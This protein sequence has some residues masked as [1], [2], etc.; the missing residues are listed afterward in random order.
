MRITIEIDGKEMPTA[1]I[2]PSAGLE[3]SAQELLA[4][5]TALDTLDAG[6][7][8]SGV[9]G[10]GATFA[11]P[12]AIDGGISREHATTGENAEDLKTDSS[13]KEGNADITK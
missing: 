7:A 8:P 13:T 4:R 9:A 5:G 1:T 12:D 10:F 2:Q 6:R 11:A 3:T